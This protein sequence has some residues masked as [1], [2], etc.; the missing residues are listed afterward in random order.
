MRSSTNRTI[1]GDA[2]KFE[3]VHSQVDKQPV[4]DFISIMHPCTIKKLGISENNYIILEHEVTTPNAS[5]NLILKIESIVVSSDNKCVDANLRKELKPE[6]I[7]LDQTYREALAIKRGEMVTVITTKMKMGL[8]DRFKDMINFQKSVV[9]VQPNPTYMERKIPI[10]CVCDEMINSIGAVM[11]DR[12]IIESTNKMGR[13]KITATCAPLT[14]P[15]QEM[16]DQIGFNNKQKNDDEI[17]SN[18]IYC[19]DYDKAGIRANV[20]CNH[21]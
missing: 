12:I 6:Q 13:I 16:H 14:P 10:I 7:C 5:E 15:M 20:L 2:I 19:G 11:G 21:K 1:D 3:V 4:A 17:N 9:R 8:Q 18:T